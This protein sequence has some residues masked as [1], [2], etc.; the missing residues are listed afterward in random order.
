MKI[1]FICSRGFQVK[2]YLSLVRSFEEDGEKIE[3]IFLSISRWTHGGASR[4]L[5]DSNVSFYEVP[6]FFSERRPYFSK[7]TFFIELL[8][9]IPVLVY[10]FSKVFKK[11]RP[12]AIVV[13]QKKGYFE[14]I[15][16]A[17]AQKYQSS[18]IL[19]Q[20]GYE[21]FNDFQS[22]QISTIIK[23][24]FFKILS[25]NF[26]KILISGLQGKL[27]KE[28]EYDL[29][30]LYSQYAENIAKQ[31]LN[32]KE[33]YICGNLSLRSV[34]DLQNSEKDPEDGVLICSNG[35]L[36]YS[37]LKMRSKTL[38]VIS[39]LYQYYRECTSVKIRLKPGEFVSSDEISAYSLCDKAFANN[40]VEIGK[41]LQE[42]KYVICPDISTV[43]LE[44]AILKK[45]LLTYSIGKSPYN[46]FSCLYHK[47][48]VNTIEPDTVH[49]MCK[50][51]LDYFSDIN[52]DGFEFY[53]GTLKVGG[54]ACAAEKI[55]KV[56]KWNKDTYE[57]KSQ[58]Y[59]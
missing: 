29:C 55:C 52:T 6:R 19:Y 11:Y 57:E 50:D 12:D 36:R 41:Q 26:T 31:Q 21:M 37:N 34:A 35:F 33:F 43:G 10:F 46:F 40:T 59:N 42:Y 51:R 32:C 58:H 7:K 14:F 15:L 22:D 8:F 56:I 9:S 38:S 25:Y 13:E 49:D 24:W 16:S 53:T 3:P 17:F 1:V 30:L 27:K 18:L 47:I 20:H 44:C 45:K 39:S 48:G 28:I 5:S 54:Y 2:N 23:S 4:F